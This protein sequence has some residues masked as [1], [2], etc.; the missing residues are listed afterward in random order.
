MGIAASHPP[1]IYD[2]M[3]PLSLFALSSHLP[4]LPPGRLR[5]VPRILE[6]RELE[7]ILRELEELHL[8]RRAFCSYDA[9]SPG[10]PEK[11]DTPDVHISKFLGCG[12][13]FE[14][15]LSAFPP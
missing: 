2:S 13:S 3:L 8:P 7:S 9:P 11:E 1:Y 15:F 10:V 4:P 6:S 14:S 5:D 12:D